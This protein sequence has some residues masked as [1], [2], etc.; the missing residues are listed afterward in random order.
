MRFERLLTLLHRDDPISSVCPEFQYN[1]Y[2]APITF[3]AL[4]THMSGIGGDLPPGNA[5]GH[6]PKSLFGRGP[7][8]FNGL[9]FP[10]HQQVF[11]GVAKTRPI[12][13]PYTYPVYSNTGYSLLGIANVAANRAASGPCAPLTHADLVRQDIFEPLGFNGTSFSVTE[14]NIHNVVV[15]SINPWEIVRGF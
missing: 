8:T 12:M 10:S 6:W 15:S 11:D 4:M 2:Y 9:E 3:R 14:G 7:P 13:A 1:N 5:Q